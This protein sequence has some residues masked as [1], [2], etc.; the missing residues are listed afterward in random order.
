MGWGGAIERLPETAICPLGFTVFASGSK[1][2][3]SKT[4]KPFS[5]DL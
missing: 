5:V 4:T 3:C 2:S 1:E